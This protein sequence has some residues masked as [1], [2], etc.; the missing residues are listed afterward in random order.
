MNF[1]SDFVYA[2]KGKAKLPEI[3]KKESAAASSFSLDDDELD[4]NVVSA[5]FDCLIETSNA[6]AGDPVKCQNCEAIFSKI[7]KLSSPNP[8]NGKRIWQCEFCNFQNQIFIE[9]E[10]KPKEDEVTYVLES[11][12]DKTIEENVDN[13]YLIYCI[14]IS[15]SMSVT[16]EVKYNSILYRILIQKN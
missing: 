3:E 9:E 10:E 6:H 4:T 14:D 13:K 15:G 1:A 12:P 5:K 11:A 2:R 8:V 16:T 7:S